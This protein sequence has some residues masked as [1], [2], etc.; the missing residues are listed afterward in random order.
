MQIWTFGCFLM[1]SV[2]KL[3]NFMC[4]PRRALYMFG[5]TIWDNNISKDN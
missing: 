2:G 3:W 5:H 4:S 1:D